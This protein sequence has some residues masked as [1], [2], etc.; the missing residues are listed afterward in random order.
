MQSYRTYEADEQLYAA[1]P[2]RAEGAIAP[3]NLDRDLLHQILAAAHARSM[4]AHVQIAPTVVPGLRARDQV[5]CPD[6]SF[7]DPERRVARQGC[8]SNP[9]VRA[10][11]LAL[12]RDTARHFPEADGLFLDWVEYTVYDLPDH[13]ACMCP[14][15]AARASCRLPVAAYHG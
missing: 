2:Y 13:F 12:V 15:C 14:H 7:P 4:Q 10:Y 11:A 8:L 1:T 3:E 5:H 9:A 6:G